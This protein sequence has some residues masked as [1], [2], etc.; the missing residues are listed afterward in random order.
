MKNKNQTRRLEKCPLLW[1]LLCLPP[2]EAMADPQPKGHIAND[3]GKACHYSQTTTRG[4]KYFHQIP[5]SHSTLTFLDPACMKDS[6]LGLDINKMMINN[7]LA[8]WYS[9]SGPAFKTEPKQMYRTSVLRVRGQC[10]QSGKYP[11]IGIA[12]EY[13]IR[14]NSITEVR[15]TATVGACEK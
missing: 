13:T 14:Q 15:H 10:I 5:G 1:L 2:L 7:V 6:G 9:H 11:G 4:T 3:S 8:R 12:V